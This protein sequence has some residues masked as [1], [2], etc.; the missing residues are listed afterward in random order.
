MTE[1]EISNQKEENRKSPNEPVSKEL[2]LSLGIQYWQLR[3]GAYIYPVKA[4][5]WNP[6]DAVDP[7]LAAIRD[8]RGY[9]YADII[10]VRYKLC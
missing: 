3:A 7:D 10:S 1:G 5:P 9:S 8:A 4:V 6:A 2:L